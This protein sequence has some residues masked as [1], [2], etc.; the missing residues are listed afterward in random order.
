[1]A[2]LQV[3]DRTGEYML[4][5][6][7]K[8]CG[9]R[10]TETDWDKMEKR[11]KKVKASQNDIDEIKKAWEEDNGKFFPAGY[12]FLT[13]NAIDGSVVDMTAGY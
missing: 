1:M 6:V 2:Q 12:S 8:F 7:W 11:L 13:V 10:G 3:K 4:A 9:A 5:P